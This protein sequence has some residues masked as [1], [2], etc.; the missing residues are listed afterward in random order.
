M[1]FTEAEVT[2]D[3][4]EERR[5]WEVALM[6]ATA[7]LIHFVRYT[8]VFEAICDGLSIKRTVRFRGTI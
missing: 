2:W 8:F 1:E 7:D 6:P 5:C 3:G 4:R